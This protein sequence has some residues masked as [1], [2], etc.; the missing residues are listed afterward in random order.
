MVEQ[1]AFYDTIVAMEA[2]LRKQPKE[3]DTRWR[4]T[5]P[6][7]ILANIF[8]FFHQEPD[9]RHHPGQSRI[10]MLISGTYLGMKLVVPEDD[11]QEGKT[12][13]ELYM[14][15][16]FDLNYDIGEWLECVAHF[17]SLRF[18]KDE[19]E[20]IWIASNCMDLMLFA[21]VNYDDDAHQQAFIEGIYAPLQQ[22]LLW[23]QKGSV[24]DVPAIDIVNNQAI[25]LAGNMR[26][27]IT[28]F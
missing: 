24:Y 3:S 25:A 15:A 11:R 22:I 2:S 19:H 27:D 13:E 14:E 6:D 26:N 18:L 17:F 16:A 7:P 1:R 23:M 4:S 5:P 9:R 28:A 20:I 10:Q 12:K 21:T 8:P